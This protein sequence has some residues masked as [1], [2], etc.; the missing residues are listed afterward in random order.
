MVKQSL[1]FF[2]KNIT[3]LSRNFYKYHMLHDS[4]FKYNAP[5]KVIFK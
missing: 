5:N 3:L 2:L 4:H 1:N